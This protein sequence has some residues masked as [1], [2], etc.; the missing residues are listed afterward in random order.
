MRNSAFKRHE[1]AVRFKQKLQG[2][3]DFIGVLSTPIKEQAATWLQA[4]PNRKHLLPQAMVCTAGIHFTDNKN[5]KF[6]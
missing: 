4:Q 2:I 6:K 3:T 5:T 1:N